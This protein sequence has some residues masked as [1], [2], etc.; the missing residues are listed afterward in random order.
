[1]PSIPK[2]VCHYNRATSTLHKKH[3]EIEGIISSTGENYLISQFADDTS[4]AILNTPGNL[5][6]LLHALEKFTWISGL[7]LN[8]EKSELLL[9][10]T[11][12]L[13]DVPQSSRKLVKDEVKMLGVQISTNQQKVIDNNYN[14]VLEKMKN[15]TKIWANRRMSLAGKIAI[16]KTLLISQLI[17]CMTV[18]PSPNQE[19]WSKVNKLLFNFLANNKGERLKRK[20][21][22]GPYKEGGFCMTDIEY[23]NR[24]I[25][26]GWIKRLLT[27]DG[28]WSSFIREKLPKVELEYLFRCNIRFKDLRTQI[29]TK[30]AWSEILKEWCN[31]NFKEEVEGKEAVYNQNLWLNSHIKIGGE[32]GVNWKWYNAGIKWLSDIVN[33]DEGRMLTLSEIEFKYDI[34]IP[35][36]EYLGLRTSIPRQW[37]AAIGAVDQNEEEEDYKWIDRVMD[38]KHHGKMIYNHLVQTEFIAPIRKAETCILLLPI[39]MS[40]QA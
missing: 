13:W 2:P 6:R 17:Y 32:A 36:T 30:S 21:L 23:Q 18:L 12:S 35:F 33:E 37:W 29:P 34:A 5:D 4:F 22:I 40:L 28:V 3:S 15:R 39:Q 9:L 1:M 8:V 31:L 16:C 11:S 7:K 24:T 14:P 19:Y 10:G 25:K 26:I 38:N 27:T 20:T